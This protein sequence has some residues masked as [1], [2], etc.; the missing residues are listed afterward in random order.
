MN[1]PTIVLSLLLA[2]ACADV[3]TTTPAPA[4]AVPAA[5]A[6]EWEGIW[7]STAL[8]STGDLLLRVQ[9]FDGQPVVQIDT[10]LP[11]I[12]GTSFQLDFTAT[13][14]T[15]SIG[16][17]E[18]LRG[19]VAAD[20]TLSGTYACAAGTGSWQAE[21]LR[22][23]PAVADLSGD[24][25]G[26]LY[27]EGA[28]PQ[29]FT[30]DLQMTLESGVLRLAGAITVQGEPTDTIVGYASEFDDAG[31]QVFFET[32]GGVLRAQGNG[33]YGPLRVETGQWG[34]FASGTPIG[35]G[36]FAMERSTP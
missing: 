1:R 14:F 10:D 4:P 11:C 18:V 36:V 28:T 3:T 12:A 13:S 8:E 23:L 29:P 9:E 16:D 30:L 26:A 7:T 15:A 5:L 20:G 31:Y 21:R 19:E 35:G 6:G 27:R 24:W 2:T 25:T 17:Q 32:S 22:P 34:V 33:S